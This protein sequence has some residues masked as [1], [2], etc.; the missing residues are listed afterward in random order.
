MIG[1]VTGAGFSLGVSEAAGGGGG[2]SNG[3]GT[4]GVADTAVSVASGTVAAAGTGNDSNSCTTSNSATGFDAD[5]SVN[6]GVLSGA[7]V[8]FDRSTGGAGLVMK[9]A[10]NN[11]WL[12]CALS[13]SP[14]RLFSCTD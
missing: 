6:A 10:H 2:V 9:R 12:N 7:G 3:T 8:A 1:A 14:I 5:D 13:C 11:L 4:S